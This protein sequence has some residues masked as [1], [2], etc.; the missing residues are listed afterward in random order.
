MVGLWAGEAEAKFGID[1]FCLFFCVSV[2]AFSG[3]FGF[4][5]VISFS[6]VLFFV[7]PSGFRTS[8]HKKHGLEKR[9]QTHFIPLP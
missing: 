2:P 7:I 8:S 1:F 9:S 6:S 5:P 3:V 4:S